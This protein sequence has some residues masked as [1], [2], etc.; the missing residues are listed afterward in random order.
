MVSP[1]FN[2]PPGVQ[3]RDLESQAWPRCRRCDEVLHQ[4]ARDGR[5]PECQPPTDDDDDE[6]ENHE[7]KLPYVADPSRN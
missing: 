6:N 4:R 1:L 3:R 5:C 2:L 7:I